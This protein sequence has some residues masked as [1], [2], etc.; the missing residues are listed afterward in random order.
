MHAFKL[1][2]ILV[3]FSFFCEAHAW[4]GK[5]FSVSGKTIT[6]ATNDSAKTK[7]GMVVYI[8]VDGKEVGRGRVGKVFHTKVEII[9]QS[10]KAAAG[11]QV[12]STKPVPAEIAKKEEVKEEKIKPE[13]PAPVNANTAAAFLSF[14]GLNHGDSA[15][16]LP[17]LF[18]PPGELE[19]EQ[20]NDRDFSTQFYFAKGLSISVFNSKATPSNVG[21]VMT[22]SVRS[23][24]AA[25]NLKSLGIKDEK[26]DLVGLPL[27]AITKKFGKPDSAMSGSYEY[28]F[29]ANGKK[30][31]VTF[32]CYEFQ[33][34]KCNE[35]YVHW[36]R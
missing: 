6:V 25:R 4:N 27:E 12:T 22:V 13:I 26:L 35:I 2:A 31:K 5:V 7:T 10:G 28:D 29:R 8:V 18:G 32:Y 3:L 34:N 21:K 20:K 30:G 33:E 16:Q 23:V 24:E 36:F 11:Y 15:E 19:N 14:C 17:K 9:L 1:S